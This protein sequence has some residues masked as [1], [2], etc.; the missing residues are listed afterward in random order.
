MTDLSTALIE[1]AQEERERNPYQFAILMGLNT[2][3]KHVY[4]G[5]VPEAEIARRRK[6]NKAARVQRRKNRG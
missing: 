2:T 6:A 5:T 3:G 4:A 1:E